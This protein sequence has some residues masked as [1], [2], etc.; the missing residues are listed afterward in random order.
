MATRDSMIASSRSQSAPDA[1]ATP[2]YT[3]PLAVVTTLFFNVG[4]PDVHE[5]RACATSEGDLRPDLRT[6]HVTKPPTQT[7]KKEGDL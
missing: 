5:R 1:A 2:D 7:S 4:F 3:R 6:S